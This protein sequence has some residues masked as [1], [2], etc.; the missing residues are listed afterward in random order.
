M[1]SGAY[2]Q[3]HRQLVEP[4]D[5]LT[6][7]CSQ[8]KFEK[9]VEM[10]GLSTDSLLKMGRKHFYPIWYLWKLAH[11]ITGDAYRLMVLLYCIKN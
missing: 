5:K 4:I 1:K 3:N 6:Q 9:Q 8:T 2:F 10:I 7:Y 11:D